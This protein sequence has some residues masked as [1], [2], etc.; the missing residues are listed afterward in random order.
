MKILITGGHV[1]PAL[2]VIAELRKDKTIEIIFVGRQY[3]SDS[4]LTL[5]YEYTQIEKLGIPF[6]HLT[7]GKL[8]RTLAPETVT[9]LLKVII[10][11]IQSIT[12]MKKQRPEA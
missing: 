5:T 3:T 12:I 1:T 8:S 7:T 4:E 9:S 6:I 11:L 10:G 2:A